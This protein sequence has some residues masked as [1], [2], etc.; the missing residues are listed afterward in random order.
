MDIPRKVIVGYDLCDDFTQISCYSYKTQEPVPIGPWDMGAG[1]VE[2]GTAEGKDNRI[3][4]VLC[5][6]ADT[7][8]WLFGEE[9][10]ACAAN[11]A[12]ILVEQLLQKVRR[13]EGVELLETQFSAVSLLEKFFRKSLALIRNH[14]PTD[15]ITR[16]VVTVPEPEPELVGRIYEAL[17]QLGLEKDRALVTSHAGAYLYYA[18]YQDRNLWMN[19]VGLFEFNKEG[20]S[21]YQIQINRR[22]RPMVAGL[23]K[24]DLTGEINFGVL[25]KKEVNP[26]YLFENAANM[27]LHRQL[28]TTLYFA[29]K[30]FEGGWA[31][32]AIKGL[33]VGRRGFVGQNLFTLGACFA[34]KELSGDVKLQD[35]LLLN[36]D[37]VTTSVGVRVYRDTKYIDFPLLEAGEIWYEAEKELEVIPEGEAMLEL[38]LTDIKSGETARQRLRLDGWPGKLDRTTRLGIKLCCSSRELAV[39]KV[40]DLGFGELFPGTGKEMVFTIQ[41]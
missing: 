16:L 5:V 9:A 11:G 4:T 25:S 15:P 40:T 34:A 7:K 41:I 17:S 10:I 8:Q 37:M 29:G 3:P 31:D 30:G 32:E 24:T 33:C 23:L 38:S 26:A 20:L 18:L 19:D 36:D 28:V 12:G 2:L 14:F 27:V 13:N 1:S 21:Y 6:K 22:S 39:M 35:I